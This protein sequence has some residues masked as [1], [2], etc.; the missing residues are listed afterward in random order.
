MDY[1]ITIL[2]ALS[3]TLFVISFFRKERNKEVDKQI[4]NFSITLM[5]EIY[6]LKKKVKILEEEIL[7]GQDDRYFTNNRSQNNLDDARERILRLYEKGHSIEEI[8]TIT[9]LTTEQINELLENV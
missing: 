4:E 9:G 3:V 7:I 6:Q 2:F 8:A 5:Q 1:T